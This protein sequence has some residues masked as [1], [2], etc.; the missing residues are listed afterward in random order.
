MGKRKHDSA[1]TSG[2][3]TTSAKSSFKYANLQADDEDMQTLKSNRKQQRKD[4]QQYSVKSEEGQVLE[5]K[6]GTEFLGDDERPYLKAIK[7]RRFQS[8]D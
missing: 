2:S 4:S 1:T 3:L 8:F 5:T 7:V 6:V